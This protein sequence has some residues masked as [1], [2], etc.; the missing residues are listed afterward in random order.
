MVSDHDLTFLGNVATWLERSLHEPSKY[1]IACL[2]VADLIVVMFSC[3]INLY[4]E[5]HIVG[6]TSPYLC[7]IYLGIDEV[8]TSASILTHTFISLD[9][10]LKICKPLQYKALM[11]TSKAFTAIFVLWYISCAIATVGMFPLNKTSKGIT[12]TR[13]FMNQHFMLLS[14][15][16]FLFQPL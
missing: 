13:Y 14:F 4:E 12:T 1:Y 15:W 10:Y 6:I 9:R 2:A 5:L 3:P 7:P 16:S 8:A 11:T